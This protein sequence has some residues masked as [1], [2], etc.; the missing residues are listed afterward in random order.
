M[1]LLASIGAT[2]ALHSGRQT[3][4]RR[5]LQPIG[6]GLLLG[7]SIALLE[8]AFYYPLVSSPDRLGLMSLTSELLSWG[9]E[10][11]LLALTVALSGRSACA[12]AAGGWRSRWRSGR[13]A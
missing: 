5:W 13:S 6:Y 1:A 10:G 9:G 3:E 8:F 11:V 12:R 2:S 7:A 4:R